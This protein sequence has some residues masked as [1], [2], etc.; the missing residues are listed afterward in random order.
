MS[1]S[2]PIQF[3]ENLCN[4]NAVLPAVEHLEVVVDRVLIQTLIAVT[5]LETVSVAILSTQQP[6]RDNIV[7]DHATSVETTPEDDR[8]N[9]H[10]FPP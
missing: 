4:N 10:P 2:A 8:P 7:Q 1:I 9:D 6:R 5:G 3:T